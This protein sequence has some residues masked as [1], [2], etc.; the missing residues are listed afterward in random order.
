MG[1]SKLPIGWV[2]STAIMQSDVGLLRS[3]CM[4]THE[5]IYATREGMMQQLQTY[6]S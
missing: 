3:E 4:E 2:A 1:T 6:V 5:L